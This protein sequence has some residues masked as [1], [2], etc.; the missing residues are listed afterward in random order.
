MADQFDAMV[1]G[2][3]TD[4][5]QQKMLAAQLRNQSTLGQ[6]FQV[7]GDR[8]VAPLGRQMSLGAQ[9]QGESIAK[10]RESQ[11]ALAQT[12]AIHKAQQD[13]EAAR[14]T[15][16][17]R[18]NLA[19]EKNAAQYHADSLA[20]RQQL[21]DQA[22]D[23]LNMP[24]EGKPIPAGT[25]KEI[26]AIKDTSD[27]IDNAIATYKPEYSGA[28][29]VI[30]RSFTNYLASNSP[31]I[32]QATGLVNQSDMDAAN[33]KQNYMRNFTL[34]EMH[35]IFG[36]RISPTEQAAFEKAHITDNQPPEVQQQNM[37]Q[38]SARVKQKLN[39]RLDAL[40]ASG[41]YAKDEID[42]L[43]PGGLPTAAPG[44]PNAPPL[45]GADKYR[46]QAKAAL[47]P[48]PAG[49]GVAAPSGSLLPQTTGQM[50]MPP[51]QLPSVPGLGNLFQQPLGQTQ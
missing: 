14:L 32:G 47:A 29:K 35:R 19:D 34:D 40:Q 33:W 24:K 31:A 5:E 26:S 37:Q 48:A 12:M 9:Q 15:E 6:M 22:G 11:S 20:I 27:S 7:T 45:T 17:G 13:Q 28:G 41:A 46:A 50:P 21:A 1:S 44:A 23:K 36:A 25:L 43:R 10:E 8:A 4:P 2:V 51:R 42:A 49:P 30:P 3:S 16:T 39:E 38:I 18:H